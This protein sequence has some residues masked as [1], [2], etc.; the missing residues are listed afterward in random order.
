MRISDWSSD[1]CSSD[2]FH[3]DSDGPWRPCGWRIDRF[4]PPAFCW[5]GRCHRRSGDVLMACVHGCHSG[6]RSAG[7]DPRSE[8]RRVGK[9]SVNVI[10][11]RWWPYHE[12]KQLKLTYN[13]YTVE[14]N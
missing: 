1:V 4:V 3:V 5:P 8:E 2:L 10:R 13:I 6:Y 12:N 7:T 14:C 9:E 11:S